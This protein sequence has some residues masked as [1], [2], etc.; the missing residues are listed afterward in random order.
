MASFRLKALGTALVVALALY[1][2]V[3][4][5]ALPATAI[6]L[7]I[8]AAVLAWGAHLYSKLPQT[9]EPGV[10]LIQVTLWLMLMLVVLP[11]LCMALLLF[12]RLG[13]GG[14]ALQLLGYL[15]ALFAFVFASPYYWIPSALF[16]E[17]Y[18]LQE[19]VVSPHGWAG[20]GI[21]VL[22]W[23]LVVG[24]V[25]AGLYFWAQRGRD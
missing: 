3:V 5:F 2:A 25:M 16:G 14:G 9:P 19:T 12:T 13:H 8:A 10:A 23:L 7:I 1:L 21:S 17:T 15:L 11:N 6:L 24:A 4:A 20:I 18:F 22:F